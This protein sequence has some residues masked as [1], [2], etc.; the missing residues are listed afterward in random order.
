[1]C[2][3]MAQSQNVAH[4]SHS[5]LVLGMDGSNSQILE[6]EG[7]HAHANEAIVMHVYVYHL[8]IYHTHTHCHVH[9]TS[10]HVCHACM[11]ALTHVLIHTGDTHHYRNYSVTNRTIC[12]Y[13]WS[14]LDYY[15]SR[16]I[17][18][19]NITYVLYNTSHNTT[20]TQHL[21]QYI[22]RTACHVTCATHI[23]Y[24]ILIHQSICIVHH[25]TQ[26]IT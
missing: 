12:Y 18:W 25:I 22:P 6:R 11:H 24:H 15:T 1:M 2:M 16:I 13:P 19:Y 9:H 7:G 20:H 5:C 26:Y 21:E 23:S 10:L 14:H 4:R 3:M 17:Y 8:Y